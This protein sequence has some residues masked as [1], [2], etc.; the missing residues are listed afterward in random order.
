MS[1]YVF[2]VLKSFGVYEE[3]DTPMLADGEGVDIE[4]AITPLMNAL[5]KFRDEVKKQAN[6]GPKALF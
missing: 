3:D 2:F 1:K 6:D 4:T 5:A